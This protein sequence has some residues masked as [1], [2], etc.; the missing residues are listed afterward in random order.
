MTRRT[1][2]YGYEDSSL[3]TLSLFFARMIIKVSCS[4]GLI[5]KLMKFYLALESVWKALLDIIPAQPH[6]VDQNMVT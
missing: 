1:S 2:S 4:L 6:V 3:A 5:Y